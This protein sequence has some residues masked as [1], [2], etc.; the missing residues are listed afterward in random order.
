MVRF[1]WP[2]LY[3]MDWS[4]NLQLHKSR[5]TTAQFDFTTAHLLINCTIKYALIFGERTVIHRLVVQESQGVVSTSATPTAVLQLWLQQQCHVT[6][7]QLLRLSSA[8]DFRRT[9]AVSKRTINPLLSWNTPYHQCRVHWVAAYFSVA[10]GTT[11]SMRIL[12]HWVIS[13]FR[14]TI[15]ARLAVKTLIRHGRCWNYYWQ[16]LWHISWVTFLTFPPVMLSHRF[17]FCAHVRIFLHVL[18]IFCTSVFLVLCVRFHNK[19]N[20]IWRDVV[21]FSGW[22]RSTWGRQ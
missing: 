22:L 19:C 14:A 8:H 20:I 5:F 12:C 1:F 18:C 7:N 3:F 15:G 6:Q 13:T 16:G 21:C 2:T 9:T 17:T 11:L 10:L 4:F